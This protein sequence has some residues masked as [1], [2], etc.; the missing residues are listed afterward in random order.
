MARKIKFAL[1]MPRDVSVRTVKELKQNFDL[2][3]VFEY[4]FNGK[5]VGQ[6][7][8][9]RHNEYADAIAKLGNDKAEFKKEF[10]NVFVS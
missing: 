1:K 6:L 5:L 8:D 2:A 3:S 4:Y 7:L 10:F 9:R